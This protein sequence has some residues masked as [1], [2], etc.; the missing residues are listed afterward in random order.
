[1][2]THVNHGFNLT[3]IEATTLETGRT[4]H[5]EKGD[6]PSVTTVLSMLSKQKIQE[7]RAKV[8]EE[9]AN[10]VSRQASMRGTAVHQLAEDYI[11]NKPNWR[12][13]GNPFERAS[14]DLLKFELDKHLDNVWYQEAPLY[15]DF[16]KMAGRVDCIAEWDG[17]L[18]IIDFKTA[19]KPKKYEWITNYFLQAA[20]YSAAFYERTGVSI[21]QSVIAITVDGHSPQVFVEETYPWLK[22]L[23][24]V[25]N[26]YR[27]VYGV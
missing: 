11:N 2:F 9:E 25:R 4:Y 19:R 21:K 20:F 27:D 14:F 15:S 23:N 6:M 18:S 10:R 17:Q 8:G 16:F 1:M 22:P 3:D 7:W 13:S 24:E 12:D 5:T 26:K